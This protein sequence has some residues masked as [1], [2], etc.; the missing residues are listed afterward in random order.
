MLLALASCGPR[1]APSASADSATAMQPDT[2]VPPLQRD[3]TGA[4]Q[5]L[6]QYYRAVNQR[7]FRSAYLLWGDSGRASGQSFEQFQAGYA[8]TD[9]VMATIGRPGGVEGAAGSRYIEVPVTLQAWSGPGVPQR[10]TGT[11]VLRRS[12]VDGATPAQRRWHIYSAELHG[13]A[14][15]SDSAS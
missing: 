8:R 5:V 10:F 9:S 15:S 3:S 13:G 1:P 7:D 2:I 14:G 6:E 11:Y 12:M 4:V